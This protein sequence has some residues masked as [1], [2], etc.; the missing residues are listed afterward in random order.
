MRKRFMEAGR[1]VSTHGL[2]GE[3]RVEHW[4]DSPEMLA[5][6]KKLFLDNGNRPVETESAR[7][8][9]SMVILKI[10]GIDSIE[11][12]QLLRNKILYLDRNDFMLQPGQYFVQDLQGL[13]CIDWQSGRYYGRLTSVFKTGANDV[14]VILSDDGRE[15]LIPA[16]KDVIKEIDIDGEFIKIMPLDGIFDDE[17]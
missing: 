2:K 7:V 9:K 16:I 3:L 17:D 5:G 14:Y 4:C 8:H 12:A 10:K 1:I 13:R 15:Y 6:Q 11:E